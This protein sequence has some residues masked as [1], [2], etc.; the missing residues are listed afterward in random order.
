M[1]Q[2]FTDAVKAFFI[3]Q[4]VALIGIQLRAHHIFGIKEDI[5]DIR[6]QRQLIMAGFIKQ[7]FQGVCGFLQQR[8]SECCRT[9][10]NGV[11]AAEDSIELFTV[12][13]PGIKLQQMLFHIP[14]QL[15]GFIEERLIKLGYIHRGY[16]IFFLC[17]G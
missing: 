13:I 3:R 15:V 8:E 10:F 4:C 16:P 5:N 17:Y 2:Y 7:V 1:P 11:R 14:E 6:R 9:T 12:R